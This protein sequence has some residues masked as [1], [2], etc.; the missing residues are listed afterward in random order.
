MSRSDAGATTRTRRTNESLGAR[1]PPET[2]RAR[3]TASSMGGTTNQEQQK[4]PRRSVE[5]TTRGNAAFP[6]LG[7]EAASA[8]Q[9]SFTLALLTST[10]GMT[11]QGGAGTRTQGGAEPATTPGCFRMMAPESVLHGTRLPTAKGGGRVRARLPESFDCC[12]S[13]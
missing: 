6:A 11:G 5:V 8:P 1:I 9:A 4:P 2:S 7:M 13:G 12:P 3:T 10:N